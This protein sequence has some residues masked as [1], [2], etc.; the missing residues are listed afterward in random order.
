MLPL[1]SGHGIADSGGLALKVL[2]DQLVSRLQIALH[3]CSVSCG[4]GGYAKCE[5]KVFGTQVVHCSTM[6]G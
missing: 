1:L 3:S 2:P 6:D 4:T 5:T